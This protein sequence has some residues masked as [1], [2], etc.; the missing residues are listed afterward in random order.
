MQDVSLLILTIAIERYR[1]IEQNWLRDT[2]LAPIFSPKALS[3]FQ[4]SL[5]P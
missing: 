4:R 1:A 5:F 2:I 3:K